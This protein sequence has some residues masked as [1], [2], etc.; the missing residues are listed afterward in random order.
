MTDI[1][2]RVFRKKPVTIDAVQFNNGEH[3]KGEWLKIVPEANIGAPSTPGDPYGL[4][5]TDIRW[6]I[7]PTLEGNHEAS[8]GDWV[9]TGVE[10]E[11]Y[12][13][14]PGIFDQT[15]SEVTS[16]EEQLAHSAVRAA[17]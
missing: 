16:K 11:H 17:R 3:T 6:F 1:Q 8:D 15:Y 14:K 10:N 4:N 13:C 7:I 5:S 9:I 2:P 12:F